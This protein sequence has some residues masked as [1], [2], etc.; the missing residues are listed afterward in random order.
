MPFAFVSVCRG[1]FLSGRIIFIEM[2][3][4]A[5]VQRK[6]KRIELPIKCGFH[7]QLV[8]GVLLRA[9]S[10]MEQSA[11]LQVRFVVLRNSARLRVFDLWAT[12]IL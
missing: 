2:Y 12:N 1:V 11:L 7:F 8:D 4:N 6:K 10:E 9:L 5:I 3:S